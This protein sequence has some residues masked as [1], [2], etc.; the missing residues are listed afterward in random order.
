M[1]EG[2]G[3][4]VVVLLLHPVHLRLELLPEGEVLRVDGHGQAVLQLPADQVQRPVAG[5][6]IESRLAE[7]AEFQVGVA[8][9]VGLAPLEVA[10]EGITAP[11]PL[12][13]GH[14]AVEGAQG[15]VQPAVPVQVHGA[16]GG[17]VGQLVGQVHGHRV[18]EGQ[19]ALRGLPAVVDVQTAAGGTQEQVVR[20]VPVHIGGGGEGLHLAHAR[21]QQQLRRREGQAPQATEPVEP[22]VPRA[23]DDI[24]HPVPVHVQHGGGG[25]PVGHGQGLAVRPGEQHRRLHGKA[26]GPR[27][28]LI[29]VELPVPA[30]AEQLVRPVPVHVAEGGVGPLSIAAVVAEIADGVL[31][32]HLAEPVPIAH[33]VGARGVDALVLIQLIGQAVGADVGQVGDAL[34][35][36]EPPVGI[37]HQGVGG[38]LPRLLRQGGEDAGGILPDGGDLLIVELPGGGVGGEGAVHPLRRP[39]VLLQGA[40]G[41]QLAVEEP[42]GAVGGVGKGLLPLRRGGEGGPGD[43]VVVGQHGVG[44]QHLPLPHV[45][46]GV[47]GQ[48]PRLGQ[49][50]GGG[51]GEA[52][53]VVHG[54]QLLRVVVAGVEGGEVLQKGLEL[55]Q[56]GRRLRPGPLSG[57]ALQ[58]R[59]AG[60]AQKVRREL[61]PEH[62][63]QHQQ[64]A[65]LHV[66]HQLLPGGRPVLPLQQV[67]VGHHQV[68]ARQVLPR[69]R[70]RRRG[71]GQGG[72]FQVAQGVLPGPLRPAVQDGGGQVGLPG[73]GQ[74]RRRPLG[75]LRRPPAA[76]GAYRQHRRQ[77]PGGQPPEQG[78]ARHGSAPSPLFV[79]LS[80]L[81]S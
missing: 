26:A 52:V 25:V 51:E 71:V 24:V 40:V 6:V 42:V 29:A 47:E 56:V 30:A 68:I 34:R 60:Y 55:P 79:V 12:Q 36:Q 65:A 8:L 50:G 28:D 59:A 78:H 13:P 37:P 73:E 39:A 5:D 17:P 44:Q 74:P 67:R 72:V 58:G 1:G 38:D 35:P 3:T 11:L 27:H 62:V 76:C 10:G 22:P 32:P 23:G 53:A 31:H 46:E 14:V 48:L 45:V 61:V 63:V 9:V 66:V 16:G 80:L 77:G 49:G 64:T 54:R 15:D 20:P 7:V 75:R 41:Q 57:Q 4:Q 69:L 19:P 70:L 81:K 21:V 18:L 2:V 43:G 33:H